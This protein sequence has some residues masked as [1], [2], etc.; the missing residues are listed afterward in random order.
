MAAFAGFIGFLI[1]VGILVL[2]FWAYGT[3]I[4]GS[5]GQSKVM[6]LLMLIPIVNIIMP[7]VWGFQAHNQLLDEESEPA[8]RKMAA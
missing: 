2:Y 5:T 4:K 7:L 1:G 3:I 8:E 6:V